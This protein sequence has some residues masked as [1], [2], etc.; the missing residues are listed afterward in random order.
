MVHRS[1]ALMNEDQK[2]HYR[3][4]NENEES[5]EE[6][7]PCGCC[8][9]HEDADDTVLAGPRVLNSDVKAEGRTT[10][11]VAGMDCADEV[12]AIER[13]LKPL[14]GVAEVRVNLMRGTVTVGHDA[15]V[16]PEALRMAINKTG[17]RAQLAET[18]GEEDSAS[19]ARR[20][21]IVS[22]AISGALTGV[23]LLLKWT[24]AGPGWLPIAVFVCAII[25][26]GW[27]IMPKTIGALRRFSLDMNVLMTVAG[28]R[29]FSHRPVERSGGG[30]VPVRTFRVA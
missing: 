25:S 1:R 15:G 11:R 17:L 10:L 3:N 5:H 14:A 9:C 8:G 29:S 30:R 6:Q 19:S 13:E 18:G 22:V 27:F 7:S 24:Q 4:G 2:H 21:R 20:A 16:S 12:A 26:G 23:G 28:V